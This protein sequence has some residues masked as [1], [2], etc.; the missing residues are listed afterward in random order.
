MERVT[1]NPLQSTQPQALQFSAFDAESEQSTSE[2][3]ALTPPPFQLM[4]G[5][6]LPNDD[7]NPIQRTEEEN[8]ASN[9]A[10]AHQVQIH[11][12]QARTR[13][14]Q[15][16]RTARGLRRPANAARSQMI[17]A[18]QQVMREISAWRRSVDQR[19]L[20]QVE[21][22]HSGVILGL[23]GN[24]ADDV[25]GAI[26][27]LNPVSKVGWFIV[28]YAINIAGAVSE[29]QQISE[30]QRLVSATGTA[31]ALSNQASDRVLTQIMQ[32]Q[33]S[34]IAVFNYYYGQLMAQSSQDS[35]SASTVASDQARREQQQ[36]AQRPR[37]QSPRQEDVNDAESAGTSILDVADRA[38]RY[39]SQLRNALQVLQRAPNI[40]RERGLQT[41]VRTQ[42]IFA[43]QSNDGFMSLNGSLMVG[44]YQM[45]TLDVNP[46]IG[47]GSRRTNL[48][49][50]AS[51]NTFA[52]MGMPVR[53]E[54]NLRRGEMVPQIFAAPTVEYFNRGHL[55]CE[56]NRANHLTITGMTDFELGMTM[57]HAWWN[58][59]WGAAPGSEPNAEQRA[60]ATA[61]G[62]QV[63]TQ[64]RTTLLSAPLESLRYQ[65]L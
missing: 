65:Q 39:L 35:G 45:P 6:D 28:K 24:I 43:R 17:G 5:E 46:Q 8:A 56:M 1:T 26:A 60:A 31:Q 42:R 25:I 51:L 34:A 64:L 63:K 58:P 52:Q 61:Y 4:A 59:R 13:I 57:M 21:T 36:A 37:T 23:A 27:D 33:G 2:G 14:R 47:E 12:Q 50:R 10:L 15:A 54:I 53:V 55:R 32:M 18:S 7:G 22:Q 44:R 19:A 48:A 40:I 11:A 38:E 16:A 49:G 41:L 30:N 20:A 29:W 62:R 9:Q 3:Q